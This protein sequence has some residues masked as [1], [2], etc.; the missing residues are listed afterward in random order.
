MC[1]VTSQGHPYA[2]FRRALERRNLTLSMSANAS[3]NVTFTEVGEVAVLDV[4]VR[5]LGASERRRGR[6]ADCSVAW[7]GFELRGGFHRP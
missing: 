2:I 7:E 6:R 3:T 5:W 4:F 1:S